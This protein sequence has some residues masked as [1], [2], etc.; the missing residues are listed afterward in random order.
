[1]AADVLIVEDD[2]AIAELLKASLLRAGHQ[3]R[4]ALDAETAEKL[5]REALRER[6]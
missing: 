3:T 4:H 2:P 6:H 1:M 5:V